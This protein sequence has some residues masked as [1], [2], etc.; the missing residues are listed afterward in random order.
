[1]V[2]ILGNHNDF[3]SEKTAVKHLLKGHTC[4]C[5]IHYFFIPKFQ[6][7]LNPIEK[8]WG[9]AKLYTLGSIVA[10]PLQGLRTPSTSVESAR[11]QST[12]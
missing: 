9:A 1:M 5:R 10:T 12:D 7:E 4:T 3:K 6:C 8:V 2:F 11:S